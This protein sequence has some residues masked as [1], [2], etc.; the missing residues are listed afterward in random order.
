SLVTPQITHDGCV[1][2]FDALP[3]NDTMWFNFSF[4]SEEYPEFVFSGFNDV[5]AILLSGPGISGTINAAALPSGVPVTI[6]NVN[7]SV[8]SAYYY[9]NESPAG[10]YCSFDGFTT[11]LTAFA[12]VIPDS[13]YHFKVAIADVGDDAYDSGVMLEA[14]SFRCVFLNTM[15]IKDEK[16]TNSISVYPNPGTGIYT[17]KDEQHKLQG[18]SITIFN[19]LGEKINSQLIE[20][21]RSI[22][23]LT[24]QSSGVYF[25]QI[26]TP[27]GIFN[28][29]LIKK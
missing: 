5:F 9:N 1:L 21:E 13:T 6:D 29:K 11:N 24:N 18:S 19:V 26:N 14:F 4:G 27:D 23:D 16:I 15:G 3:T 22:I 17:L 28:T 12:Q 8:N 25:I 2:N 20:N 10:L 7:D